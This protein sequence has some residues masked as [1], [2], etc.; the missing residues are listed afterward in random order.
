MVTNNDIFVLGPALS[1]SDGGS[2]SVGFV[3][4]IV[5]G[6]KAASGPPITCDVRNIAR[7][8][9]LAA[10][11]PSAKGRHFVSQP[12]AVLP[13]AMATAIRGSRARRRVRRGGRAPAQG[14][15]SA[16]GGDREGEDRREQDRERARRFPQ[17]FRGDAQGR[18]ASLIKLGVAVPASKVEWKK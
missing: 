14:R 13:E 10:E 1:A 18:G 3:K 9:V 12:G 6:S 17:V 15:G 11:N 2:I 5:E 16:G 4:G 7:A 8:H